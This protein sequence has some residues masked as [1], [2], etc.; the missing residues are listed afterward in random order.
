[1]KTPEDLLSLLHPG[2]RALVLDLAAE[3]GLE[4]E[5]LLEII[6]ADYLERFTP[7]EIRERI[8]SRKWN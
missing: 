7:E 5:Q 2:L 6:L 3:K 8:L 1:M 4:P